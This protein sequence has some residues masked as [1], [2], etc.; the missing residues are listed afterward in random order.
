MKLFLKNLLFTLFIPSTLTVYVPLLIAHGQQ[1]STVPIFFILGVLLL[2]VGAAVYL[3]MVWDF[4]ISGK[5]TP[6]SLA[7]TPSRE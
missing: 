1:V 5:G 3:W 6:M 4:A 7:L 2:A